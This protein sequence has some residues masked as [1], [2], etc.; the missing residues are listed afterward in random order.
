MVAFQ[1]QDRKAFTKALF[2]TETFDWFL[3]QEAVIVT[4][5]TFTIQGA[6]HRT[7]YSEEELE[8]E[9]IEDYSCWKRLR[10]FCFSLIKGQKLPERFSITLR[11]PK[12]QTERF[13]QERC[14]SYSPE[15]VGGLFLQIRYENQS[16]TAVTGVSLREFRMEKTLE[17]EWDE[18]IRAFLKQQKLPFTTV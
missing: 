6:V 18:Q 11:L 3:V 5:N 14:A 16:L 1:I 10:P 8:T 15:E 9:R 4:F 12:K 13:L 7:Y 2:L 17:H